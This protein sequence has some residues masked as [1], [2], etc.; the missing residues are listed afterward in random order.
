MKRVPKRIQQLY[1][2]WRNNCFVF[3]IRDFIA[4]GNILEK[5]GAKILLWDD[6]S[7]VKKS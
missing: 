3:S 1:E 7:V 6:I 2:R 4:I 5:E